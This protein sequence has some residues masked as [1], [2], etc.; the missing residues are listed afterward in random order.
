[1]ICNLSNSN[2]VK[3]L[4]RNE[5]SLNLHFGLSDININSPITFTD[6]FIELSLAY[7]SISNLPG[8]QFYFLGFGF[9]EKQQQGNDFCSA[10]SKGEL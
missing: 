7:S 3:N 2:L 4:K 10:A 9:Y 5:L 1:M 8:G 6:Q